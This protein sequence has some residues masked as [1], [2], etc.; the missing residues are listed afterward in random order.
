MSTDDAGSLYNALKK[1]YPEYH[2]QVWKFPHVPK[3]YWKDSTNLMSGLQEISEKLNITT[4]DDWYRVS[5]DQLWSTGAGHV[6]NAHGGLYEFLKKVYPH[7]EWSKDKLTSRFKKAAQRWLKMALCQIFNARLHLQ[8][9]TLPIL[10]KSDNNTVDIFEDFLHPDVFYSETQ[11]RM[12]LDLFIPQLNLALEYQGQHHFYDIYHFGPQSMLYNRDEAKKAACKANNITLIQ[13]P[14]WWNKDIYSLAAT[15]HQHIPNLF[16][17]H[18][19]CI[20]PNIQSIFQY[21]TNPQSITQPLELNKFVHIPLEPPSSEVS[22]SSRARKLMLAMDWN[23]NIDVGGW[24]M[25]EK[26]DGIRATWD[27][28]NLISRTGVPIPAPQWFTDQLP[29]DLQ[30][31]GE[32]W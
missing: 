4:L 1:N 5:K 32:L 18:S 10:D 27:G 17:E 24:W 30:L 20:K 11:A 7:K 29:K 14:Y 16:Q 25:T 9:N 26:Y 31:D 13:I 28:K 6:I 23:E 3:G 2:W 19:T 22:Q 15:I 8:T 12:Q 21:L